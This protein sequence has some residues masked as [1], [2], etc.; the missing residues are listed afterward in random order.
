MY[1]V[2]KINNARIG[3]DRKE[4]EKECDRAKRRSGVVE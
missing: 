2:V 3:K 1:G 4:K